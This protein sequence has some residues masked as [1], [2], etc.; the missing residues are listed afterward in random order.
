MTGLRI[1]RLIVPE[2]FWS[3]G[4][5]PSC[6]LEALAHRALADP[7][8]FANFQRGAGL[9]PRRPAIGWG[10][11]AEGWVRVPGAANSAVHDPR[12][13]KDDVRVVTAADLDERVYGVQRVHHPERFPEKLEGRERF[14]RT[15]REHAA[16]SAQ[17]PEI[18]PGF[19]AEQRVPDALTLLARLT[20][21]EVA[22][23]QAMKPSG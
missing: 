22:V 20:G 3:Q 15:P 7:H 10:F 12:A 6:V 19:A 1:E 16:D 14:V 13:R 5:T 9:N 2:A 21:H 8:W 18:E 4:E 11:A 17:I 23:R